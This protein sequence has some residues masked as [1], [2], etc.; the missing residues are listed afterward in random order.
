M[1]LFD[2]LWLSMDN[3]SVGVST[4]RARM[5]TMVRWFLLIAAAVFILIGILRG[6]AATVLKKAA[7]ICFEC[8]GLG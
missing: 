8:I 6:E 2:I 3:G 4:M 5:L 1:V 7:N